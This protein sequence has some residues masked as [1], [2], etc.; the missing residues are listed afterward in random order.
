M[1][2]PHSHTYQLVAHRIDAVDTALASGSDALLSIPIVTLQSPSTLSTS[3]WGKAGTSA[4]CRRPCLRPKSQ[5]AAHKVS[6]PCTGR[7][8]LV[9]RTHFLSP[10][11]RLCHRLHRRLCSHHVAGWCTHAA[12]PRRPAHA[13]PLLHLGRLLH[14]HV[15]ARG[16]H[17][18]VRVVS[19][20]QQLVSMR[21]NEASIAPTQS[22]NGAVELHDA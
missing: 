12:E 10:C 4:C 6:L 5:A 14:Q 17:H 1:T 15:P 2:L 21:L 19:N 20:R 3:T 7:L 18:V 13:V 11:Q 22:R 9:A 16:R 8:P